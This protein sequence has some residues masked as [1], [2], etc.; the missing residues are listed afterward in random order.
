MPDIVRQ[1]GLTIG[2][3]ANFRNTPSRKASLSKY[4]ANANK[5][6]EAL[7][8]SSVRKIA[9]MLATTNKRIVRLTFSKLET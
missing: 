7:E 8:R 9:Y 2:S 5:R 3:I 1:L 4:S 6:H